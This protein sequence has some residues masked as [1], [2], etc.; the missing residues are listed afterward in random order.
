MYMYMYMYEGAS[1]SL[2]LSPSLSQHL[3]CLH[4]SSTRSGKETEKRKKRSSGTAHVILLHV[5][6]D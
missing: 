2:S 5:H 3:T 1:L 6:V 4:M